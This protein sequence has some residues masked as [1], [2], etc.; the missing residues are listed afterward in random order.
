[1][2]KQFGRNRCLSNAVSEGLLLSCVV[3]LLVALVVIAAADREYVTALIFF[4]LAELV[5]V[6]AVDM[7][8]RGYN[9][10]PVVITDYHMVCSYPFG[11]RRVFDI[12]KITSFKIIKKRLMFIYDGWPNIVFVRGLSWE[13]QRE[14]EALLKFGGS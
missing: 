2:Y 12:N 6:S 5:A 3:L 4:G 10:F 9:E 8:R 7:I 14:L 11:K 13:N 1:M